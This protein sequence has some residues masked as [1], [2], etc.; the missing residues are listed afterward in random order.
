MRAKAE[1]EFHYM[2]ANDVDEDMVQVDFVGD[3]TTAS[4][5][6]CKAD[7]DDM[8]RVLMSI[9]D[10]KEY[11]DDDEYDEYEVVNPVPPVPRYQCTFEP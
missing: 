4:L 7:I 9:R 5:T 8:I 3:F 6:I 10:G 1:L 11:E 2:Y